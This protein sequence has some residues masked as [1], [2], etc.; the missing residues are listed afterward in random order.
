MPLFFL[1]HVYLLYL[2]PSLDISYDR[3][4]INKQGCGFVKKRHGNVVIVCFFFK[5]YCK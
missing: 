2:C 3:R 1:S 5:F 4:T